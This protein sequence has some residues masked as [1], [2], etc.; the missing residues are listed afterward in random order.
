MFTK[1]K[2]FTQNFI[3]QIGCPRRAA[4]Q[5]LSGYL[6]KKLKNLDE[7]LDF[8]KHKIQPILLIFY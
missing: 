5:E 6:I 2:I 3:E 1:T 7:K 4:L 8:L